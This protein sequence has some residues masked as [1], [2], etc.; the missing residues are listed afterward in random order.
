MQYAILQST[1]GSV[2]FYPLV[3]S[4]TY[5]R[6]CHESFSFLQRSVVITMSLRQIC[7]ETARQPLKALTF[8]TGENKTGI[9]RSRLVVQKDIELREAMKVK[10]NWQGKKVS[11]K[12]LALNGKLLIH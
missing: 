3:V 11:A 8:F 6:V 12:I 10:V 5:K 9:A 2:D 7:K 4:F 1:I